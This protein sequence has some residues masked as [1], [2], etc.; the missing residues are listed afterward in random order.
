V[1]SVTVNSTTANANERFVSGRSGGGIPLSIPTALGVHAA[2][3]RASASI[4]VSGPFYTSESRGGV[5]R[6][7]LA[8][9]DAEGGD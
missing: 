6:R 7:Q 5:E 9:K 1:A 8:L 4:D 2:G 3:E